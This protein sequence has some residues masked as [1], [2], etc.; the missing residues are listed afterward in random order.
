MRF[1]NNSTFGRRLRQSWT[2]MRARPVSVLVPYCFS[3]SILYD[4]I[5]IIALYAF[6]RFFVGVW[7]NGW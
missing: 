6:G 3:L 1:L 2:K 5:E 4:L 7:E